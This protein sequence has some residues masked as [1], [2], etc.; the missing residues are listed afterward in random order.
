ME[1]FSGAAA[2]STA[3]REHG[4]AGAS[5]DVKYNNGRGTDLSSDA[6]FACDSHLPTAVLIVL[7]VN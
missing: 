1:W 5:V 7:P 2:V 6:G 4:L 3:L